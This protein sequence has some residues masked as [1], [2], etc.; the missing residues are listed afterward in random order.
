[1]KTAMTIATVMLN[2][3]PRLLALVL[4][5]TSLVFIH[6]VLR[7]LPYYHRQMNLF[8]AF[9]FSGLAWASFALFIRVYTPLEVADAITVLFF[10]GIPLS[11]FAGANS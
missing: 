5:G 6:D 1:M 3:F 4:L 9:E 10:V 2:S 11:A 8:Q 7:F